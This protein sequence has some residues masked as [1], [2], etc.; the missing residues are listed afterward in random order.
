MFFPPKFFLGI[1][2][3]FFK[4][5]KQHKNYNKKNFEISKKTKTKKKE[6]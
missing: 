5:Q 4:E 2:K 3:F 1:F 6:L